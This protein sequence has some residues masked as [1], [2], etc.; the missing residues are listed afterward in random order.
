MA[1]V[2]GWLIALVRPLALDTFAVSAALGVA[3]LILA[4]FEM[5]MPIVGFLGGALVGQALGSFADYVAAAVLV[6]AGAMMLR[7]D[8]AEGGGPRT[9]DA[10]AGGSVSLDE[11]AIGLVIGGCG[12]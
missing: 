10:R 6:G 2:A 9:A 5:V 11:L 3:G 1:E 12:T 4:G 8:D 7:G